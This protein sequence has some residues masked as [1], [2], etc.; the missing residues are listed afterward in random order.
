MRG[1]SFMNLSW[2]SAICGMTGAL[3]CSLGYLSFGYPIMLIGSTAAI[4]A[5]RD[6]IPMQL[7]FGF[8]LICNCIGIYNFSMGI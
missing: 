7:Q 4:V 2:L 8:F 1:F 5:L 6:N 3:L